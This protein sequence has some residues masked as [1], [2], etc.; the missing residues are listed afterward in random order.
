MDFE[1]LK[2]KN[3]ENIKD[4]IK[5]AFSTEMDIDGGWG[6]DKNSATVVKYSN[7]SEK[8]QL[9]FTFAMMRATLEMTL[10]QAKE[11]RYGAI[12]VK[13]LKR[14]YFDEG[15]IEKIIYEVSGMKESDYNHFI[16][17]YKDGFGKDG[18]DI[19]KHFED[20]KKATLKREV[21]HFFKV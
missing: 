5:Q 20:R 13:E 6:Y 2:L 18:F 15:R 11:N 7:N 19:D 14:E 21:V 3:S 10:T 12:N 17:E 9:E 8:L 1:K 16:Q 4:I